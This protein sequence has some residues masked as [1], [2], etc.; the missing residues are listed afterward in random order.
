MS[1]ISIYG[2]KSKSLPQKVTITL[3]QVALLGL[4]YWILFAQG[5]DLFFGL[6]GRNS[7]EAV[8]ARYWIIFSFSILV[9]LRI[10]FTMF[11]LL[12]RKILWGESLSVPTA[13]ALYY[14]GFAVLA[15]PSS[16]PIG[17]WDTLAIAIFLFGSYLNTAS[18]LQRHFFKANPNNQGKLFT[19]GLFAH[20]MHINF[21]GDILWVSA[22]AIITQNIWSSTIVIFITLF[23]ALFNVPMLDNY[24]APR[25]GKEFDDYAARTK[26]L[27]PFVW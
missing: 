11:Y 26:R 6:F 8:P 7:A 17:I 13:F 16:A 23:F 10:T 12:K 9:F 3:I 24:L 20:S 2:K 5:R 18:E 15:L 4:A 14:I 1:S 25:Y 19:G 27:V 21:F 22:Y